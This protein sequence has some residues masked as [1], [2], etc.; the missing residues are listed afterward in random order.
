MKRKLLPLG[1]I[2]LS[3]LFMGLVTVPL[4]A[5]EEEKKLA[6]KPGLSVEYISRTISWDEDKYSSRLKSTFGLLDLKFEVQEKLFLS[7][8]IGY[9]SSDFNGLVFR[10]LPFFVAFEDEGGIISGY[11][12]GAE[13][14]KTIL[15]RPDTY[16]IGLMAQFVYYLGSRMT[17]EITELNEKMT[18]EGK[19][20]WMRAVAGPYFCYRGYE[21]WS[22]YLFINFNKLWGKF[23]MTETIVDL[24]GTEDKKIKGKALLGISIGTTYEPSTHFSLQS[25]A[26]ILPFDKGQE[27]GWRLDFGIR[28]KAIYSF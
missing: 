17:W 2:L 4:C 21:Y 11:L 24:T 15:E 10:Q 5:E 23:E 19:P 20:N 3:F 9:S 6:V 27:A 26:T 1:A 16:E 8:L 25:E 18:L 13:L 14:N 12:L 7:A 22:P 28:V